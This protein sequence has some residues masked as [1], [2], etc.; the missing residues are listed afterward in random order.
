MQGVVPAILEFPD[1]YLFDGE[2][3]L[4]TPLSETPIP[5]ANTTSNG[6]KLIVQFDKADIDNNVPAGDAVPLMLAATFVHDGVQTQLTS[7][8]TPEIVK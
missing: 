4:P 3:F 8:A 6:N 7:T 1:S 5:A 2:A